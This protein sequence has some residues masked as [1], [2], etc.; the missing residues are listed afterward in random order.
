LYTTL[1]LSRL[2]RPAARPGRARPARPRAAAPPH[3]AGTPGPAGRD[4]GPGRL[5]GL[6]PGGLH[7]RTHPGGRR[8]LEP[9]RLP[10]AH[11]STGDTHGHT[12]TADAAGALA[13]TDRPV[14]RLARRRPGPAGHFADPA[15]LDPRVRGDRAGTGRRRPDPRP[16]PLL[17]RAGRRRGR[18]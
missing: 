4:G 14:R 7:H 13:G 16:R 8:R 2:A 5:P 12:P 17:R 10:V 3:A 15:A 1:F 18:V 11:R 9:L 6:A